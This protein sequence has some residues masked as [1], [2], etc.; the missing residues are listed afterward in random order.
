MPKDDAPRSEDDRTTLADPRAF[1]SLDY[2]NKQT[3]KILFDGQCSSKS[4]TPFTVSDGSSKIRL[5]QSTWER[6]VKE[7]ISR[8]NMIIVL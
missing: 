5:P 7:K 2:D 6:E 4:P 1:L 8:T 3:E